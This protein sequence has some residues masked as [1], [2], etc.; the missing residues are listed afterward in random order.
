MPQYRRRQLFQPPPGYQSGAG[1]PPAF[2]VPP[3]QV[4]RF[5]DILNKFGRGPYSGLHGG[6]S[7]RGS[8]ATGFPLPSGAPASPVSPY[9][10]REVWGGA[11]GAGVTAPLDPSS[12][13]PVADQPK[14]GE[15][16]DGLSIPFGASFVPWRNPTT[17]QTVPITSTTPT[18]TPVLSTNLQR[19]ML[20]VQNGSTGTAPDVPPIL[21]IGFNSQPIVG[22]SFGVAYNLGAVIFDIL[23]PRDSIYVVFGPFTNGGGTVV[24]R[25]MAG[26]GT[27][28]PGT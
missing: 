28:A 22:F 14:L 21:Y 6:S 18:N 20:I 1:G 23:T 26:Q 24:I 25:G 19:N 11:Q 13:V 9:D 4:V 15:G 16:A 10:D 5:S 2:V 27:Y 12:P 8:Q 17:L 3:G 7:G